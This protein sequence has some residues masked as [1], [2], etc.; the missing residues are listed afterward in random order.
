MA[1]ELRDGRVVEIPGG[2]HDLTVEQPAALTT[3][4]ERFTAQD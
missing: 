3:T 2:G 1:H 4:V